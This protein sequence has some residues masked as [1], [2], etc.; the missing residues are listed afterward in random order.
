VRYRTE[1]VFYEAENF[2]N[3]KRP[4]RSL[5]V[6]WQ[7]EIDMSRDRFEGGLE[8]ANFPSGGRARTQ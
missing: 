3:D 2:V 8:T 4:F 5:G 6:L 1:K 7:Q